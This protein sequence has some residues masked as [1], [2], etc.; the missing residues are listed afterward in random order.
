MGPR[1]AQA[2]EAETSNGQL[3]ALGQASWRK[4]TWSSTVGRTW[5]CR[6]DP[7]GGGVCDSGVRRCEGAG[8]SGSGEH[9]RSRRPAEVADGGR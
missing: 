6:V 4:R 8:C 5:V 2:S 3:L 1:L 7:P 9:T